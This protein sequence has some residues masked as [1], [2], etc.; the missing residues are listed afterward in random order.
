[1]ILPGRHRVRPSYGDFLSSFAM[2]AHEGLYGS[3]DKLAHC[4]ILIDYCKSFGILAQFRFWKSTSFLI[5]S[6]GTC[7]A[8]DFIDVLY[9]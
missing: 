7:I 9:G 6:L 2:K 1:M 4:I 3:Y 5:I 8:F